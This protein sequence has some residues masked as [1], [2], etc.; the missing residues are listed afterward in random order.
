MEAFTNT[1]DHCTSN[2]PQNN[3]DEVFIIYIISSFICFCILYQRSTKS[4][5]T[6]LFLSTLDQNISCF[7]SAAFE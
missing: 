2:R 4:T 6:D 5:Y 3:C 7:I 1:Y